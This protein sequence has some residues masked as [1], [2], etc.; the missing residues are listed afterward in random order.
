MQQ[1]F[2]KR[3]I[4]VPDRKKNETADEH[5]GYSKRNLNNETRSQLTLRAKTPT[6][7]GIIL[8]ITEF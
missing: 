3:L 2:D 5:K 6:D 4:C 8:E 1:I 7:V